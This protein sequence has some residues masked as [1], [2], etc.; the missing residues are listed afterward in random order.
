[1]RCVS[2][3]AVRSGNPEVTSAAPPQ[4]PR[5][6]STACQFLLREL[7]HFVLFKETPPGSRIVLFGDKNHSLPGLGRAKASLLSR[8]P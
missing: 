5:Y 6:D 8:S 1:M 2:V 7:L 3:S 4:V